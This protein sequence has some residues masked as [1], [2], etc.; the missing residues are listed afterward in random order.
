MLLFTRFVASLERVSNIPDTQYNYNS[1]TYLRSTIATYLAAKWHI[2]DI[3]ISFDACWITAT[4]STSSSSSSSSSS[5]SSDSSSTTREGN[6]PTRPSSS[7]SQ[8]PSS[9][10]TSETHA[11]QRGQRGRDQP[12]TWGVGGG[13]WNKV[14]YINLFIERNLLIFSSFHAVCQCYCGLLNTYC[15]NTFKY[16]T[17]YKGNT[18]IWD[19]NGRV[20]ILEM[21]PIVQ[22]WL[23]KRQIVKLLFNSK[24]NL[25]EDH[26]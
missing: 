24:T 1:S 14:L 19:V 6:T 16:H 25:R 5:R 13:S 4:S 3:I 17:G 2:K 7:P 15:L 18:P 26:L 11:T 8:K 21:Y 9:T 20:I 23:T 22:Q 12:I 10:W